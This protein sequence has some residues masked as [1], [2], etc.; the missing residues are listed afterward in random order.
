MASPVCSSRRSEAPVPGDAKPALDIGSFPRLSSSSR[1]MMSDGEG[2]PQDRCSP[3]RSADSPAA[4]FVRASPVGA[5]SSAAGAGSG[6]EGEH[7][8][9]VTRPSD[10]AGRVCGR[11]SWSSCCGSEGSRCSTGGRVADGG[12]AP[13]AACSCS[14]LL[15]CCMRRGDGTKGRSASAA[16]RDCGAGCWGTPGSGPHGDVCG[17]PASCWRSGSRSGC[18]SC[19]LVAQP[20]CGSRGGTCAWCRLGPGSCCCCS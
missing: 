11:L 10:C 5:A 6:V 15:L 17:A 4:A 12:S 20:C 13:G 2:G 18:A 14:P 9:I 19:C 3:P 7:T 1:M 8:R 16:S